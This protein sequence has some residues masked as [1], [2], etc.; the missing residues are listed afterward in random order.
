MYMHI[1]YVLIIT[2]YLLLALGLT[3]CNQ[4]NFPFLVS[5]LIMQDNIQKWLLVYS[6]CIETVQMLKNYTLVEV[7]QI[8]V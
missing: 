3:C 4:L 8:I 6:L 2:S 7:K 5:I 1:Q